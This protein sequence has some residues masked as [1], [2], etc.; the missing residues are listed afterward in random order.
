MPE[1]DAAAERVLPMFP[2][3][4]VLLPYESIPL[5]VFEL[6]Y[7]RLVQACTEADR[8]FGIVLIARGP[9][10]GGGDVRHAL[11][12]LASIEA[13]SESPDGRFGLIA[14]GVERLRVRSWLPEDRYPQALVEIL[15]ASPLEDQVD[16]AGDHLHEELALGIEHASREVRSIRA[17]WS[18]LGS[19]RALAGDLA[20]GEGTEEQLWRLC[21]LAP[22]GPL[23]RQR[24]LEAS[25]VLGR[26]RLFLDLLR[27]L[28]SDFLAM[29]NETPH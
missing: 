4:T 16:S 21:S 14:A 11:G 2:L 28:R 9:E 17:L 5:H 25:S 13:L 22:L 20:L 29:L 8:R 26:L 7:R 15:E 27:G 3:S 18:E 23:D 12:T 19:G 10:V 1:G 24:L 6:R